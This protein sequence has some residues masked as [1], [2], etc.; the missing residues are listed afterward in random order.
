[1]FSI[2]S[3]VWMSGDLLVDQSFSSVKARFGTSTLPI[4][5]GK[6]ILVCWYVNFGLEAYSMVASS[7]DTSISALKL[8][9]TS[10]ITHANI[11]SIKWNFVDTRSR[12]RETSLPCVGNTGD[13]FDS[14]EKTFYCCTRG[15]Y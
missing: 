5:P 14:V 9:F 12:G 6:T 1:M 13:F 15:N 10:G 8:G 7:W 3:I 2:A 11:A 4:G